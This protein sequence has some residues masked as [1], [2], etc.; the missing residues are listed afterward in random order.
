MNYVQISLTYRDDR[1]IPAGPAATWGGDYWRPSPPAPYLPF[2]AVPA[3]GIDT[4]S[5]RR[6]KPNTACNP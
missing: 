2:P 3:I 6:G 1:S 4:P 5:A